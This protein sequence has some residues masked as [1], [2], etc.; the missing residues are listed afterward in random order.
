MKPLKALAQTSVVVT[1]PSPRAVSARLV[2][3]AAHGVSARD[4]LLLG[5]VR[6]A[7]ALVT[8]TAPDLH[9]V[10]GLAVYP[11]RQLGEDLLWQALSATIAILKF[12]NAHS[13]VVVQDMTGA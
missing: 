4:A 7:V 5:A 8:D 11:A 6:A 2:A 1:V 12:I 10:P 13:L 9:G 3:I